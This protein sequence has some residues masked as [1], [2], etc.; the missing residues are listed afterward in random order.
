MIPPKSRRSRTSP[1]ANVGAVQVHQFKQLPIW[2]YGSRAGG[3]RK[4]E[5]LAGMAYNQP[6]WLL[7]DLMLLPFQRFESCFQ[8]QVSNPFT[9]R[10]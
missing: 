1:Q 7:E 5:R 8:V 9:G 3:L 4:I 10:P 2:P 6:K